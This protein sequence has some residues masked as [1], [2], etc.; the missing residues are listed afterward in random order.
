MDEVERQRERR[1]SKRGR[2]G[3]R[4][5][6]GGSIRFDCIKEV[7]SDRRG[8]KERNERRDG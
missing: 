6:E 7:S 4:Q 1:V 5:G 2:D 3:G 8:C